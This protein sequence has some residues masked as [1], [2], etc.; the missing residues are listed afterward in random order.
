M[1]VK[2][3]NVQYSTN[4]YLEFKTVLEDKLDHNDPKEIALRDNSWDEFV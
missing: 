4:K 1:N 3:Q 2:T